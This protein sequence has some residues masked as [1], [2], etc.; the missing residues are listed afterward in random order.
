MCETAHDHCGQPPYLEAMATIKK[1]I[2]AKAVREQCIH[3][4]I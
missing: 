1:R 2:K 3:V 4:G